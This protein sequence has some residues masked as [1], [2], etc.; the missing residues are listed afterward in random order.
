M[1]DCLITLHN[2]SV[3]KNDII[4]HAGDFCMKSKTYAENIIKKLK[5]SHVFLSGSHDYWL[6]NKNKQQHIWEGKIA[7]QY[8]VVCHYN[9]RTWARS[10]Y[11]SWQLFGH[12]H[13]NLPPIGKQWDI[14]VDNNDFYPVSFEKI[15]EIMQ[16]RPDNP[17]FVKNYP[18]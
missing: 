14:G 2:D 6:G 18:T 1:E 4:I 13:G 12:S 5:G 7:K 16:D 11:N 3:N 17:N 8:I 9:M 15:Y 10:H